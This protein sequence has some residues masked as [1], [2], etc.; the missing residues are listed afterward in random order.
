MVLETE[1]PTPVNARRS[2]VF[3]VFNFKHYMGANPYL[4][5]GALVFDFALSGYNDPLPLDIYIETIVS[6]FSHL[7]ETS[8]ESYTE[9][10]AQ[11]V[12]EVGKLEMEL[13][14]D[15]YSIK[16]LSKA[17]R[18]AIES[19]HESTSRGVVYAVWDWFEDISRDR[20][21]NLD[22][23]IR[24]LQRRF[25]RS[26][27]GGPTVYALLDS[28]RTKDIPAFYLPDEGLMQ[29]GYGRKQVRGIATT[30]DHDSH[31]D[32]DFTTRKDDCKAFLATLGFPVP[33]GEIVTTRESALRTAERIGYP[34]AVKP[35]VGHKGIG[36]TAEVQNDADLEFAFDRAVDA[37]PEDEPIRV[38]VEQHVEGNDHRLLCVDGK[39]VAATER[40]AASVV[41]DGESTIAQLIERENARSAR[42]D[43][44]TSPLG[45]IL[46]DES[47]ERYLAEQKLDLESVIERDRLVYLRKVANLSA[48]GVSIDATPNI[49]PDNI[50][51]AQDIAQHFRLVCLGIDVLTTDISRSWKDGRFGI[52]EI[53]SAPGVYMHLRPAVGES[54]NVPDRILE[55]FFSAG[56]DA[57]IPILSFNTIEVDELQELIDYISTQHPTW[58]IG[59]VCREGVFVNRGAKQVSGDYR[60]KVQSLLRNPKLDLLIA[61]YPESVLEREGMFYDKS[62]VV[63]LDDPTETEMMLTQ[64]VADDAIVVIKEKETITVRS[65]GLLDQYQLGEH[66]P[67]K[68]VYYKEISTIL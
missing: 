11:A 33:K 47:M 52:V 34:V 58:T 44:P 49:H 42:L 57:R 19:L 37:H 39:F 64:N 36:V 67:F 17:E 63:I 55:T 1:T 54:V 41:G 40:R 28:A 43:T 59:A 30:F 7:R 35:V 62:N 65:K 53:N 15:R 61:E 16:Q 32:S 5:G 14:C 31:L 60:T 50:I 2:D 18:I 27:Y 13:R 56:T 6:R 8:F 48:G 25:R 24:V 22:E 68:R 3:D 23:Q 9:L 10:F 45:K 38:I 12:R 4:Q 21:F 66:E 29:Y 20:S 46:V 26:P 51:L